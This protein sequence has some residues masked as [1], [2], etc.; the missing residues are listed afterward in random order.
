MMSLYF[1]IRQR[2]QL[3]ALLAVVAVA[4]VSSLFFSA[5][6][7]NQHALTEV[8]EQD[9]QT[10]ARMQRIE[11]LLLE[12]RFRAAGVLLDQLPIPGSLN[13]LRDTKKELT[14]LFSSFTPV[15]QEIFVEGEALQSLA[16]LQRQWQV[17]EN[18]LGQLEKA[19]VTK[20][21]NAMTAV[22]EDDWPV[23]VKAVVKPLQALIPL[24]QQRSQNTFSSSVVAGNQRLWVGLVCAGI[25]LLLLLV[26][27]TWTMRSVLRPLAE[28]RRSLQAIT[29]GNLASTLPHLRRDEL[30]SVVTSLHTM[31]SE[32]S[33]LVRQ[34]RDAAQSIKVASAE[35]ASGNTDLSQRTEQTA[36][37]LEMTASS[38]VQLASAV[39]HS[40][41]SARQ[42]SQLA[43]SAAAVAQRGGQAVDAVM[44]TM[45]GITQSSHQI[46][47]IIGVIDS[48]AFQTNILALNAAVEAARAGEQGRG[49]A[50]VASE[51]RSLAGRSAEAAKQIKQLITTSVAGVEAGAGQVQQASTTMTELLMAVTQVATTIDEVS[52]AMADQSGGIGQI[53]EVVSDLDSVTQQN[54]ALVEQS[55][56]AAISLQSQATRL[57]S[58]ME[59]F[60]LESNETA[61]LLMAS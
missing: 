48:I 23:M 20:N 43:S 30:G 34:V 57:A 6:Q 2:L 37:S 4:I 29:Q 59:T 5:N 42:A 36:A 15:A 1:S 11:N 51:V 53:N 19:Y 32:L 24:A 10:L 14:D 18:T 56:A 45:H 7:V 21:N 38:T 40:A 49:F 22:L 61:S 58:L 8:F 9:G 47:D 55:S 39:A 28:V 31:Q 33:Q 17:V 44:Q 25:C 35:V 12:V 52:A 3:L 27:V 41:A 13:H 54:A 60:Q 50:V 46:A 16:Q 26:M